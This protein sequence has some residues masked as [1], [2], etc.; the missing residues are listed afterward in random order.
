MLFSDTILYNIKY[1]RPDATDEEVRGQGTARLP[2]CY[3]CDVHDLCFLMTVLHRV[4][5]TIA[6]SHQTR[7]M[8]DDARFQQLLV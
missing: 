6:P 5:I 2:V 1:G 4:P 8:Q 3:D 7:M